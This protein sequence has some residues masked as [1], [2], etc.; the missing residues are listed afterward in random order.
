MAKNEIVYPISSPEVKQ[1]PLLIS[2]SVFT[3][4]ECRQIIEMG[5]PQLEPKRPLRFGKKKVEGAIVLPS[6]IDWLYA[7]LAGL[8]A[9]NNC[10][11][12][13]LSGMQPMNILRYRPG[14]FTRMH[15][16]YKPHFANFAKITAI[17]Q[18]VDP[19]SY[20][21]GL[22]H[23]T[24]EGDP[25]RLECGDCVVFPSVVMHGVSRVDKGARIVLAAWAAGPQL[26]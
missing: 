14:C 15:V 23:V 26:R 5:I 10:W 24:E 21:G 22:L 13:H 7:R 2:K 11:G 1:L 16:D 8:F 12:F 4:K 20:V 17:V 18:L 3:L 9:T 6:D 25:V 19:D